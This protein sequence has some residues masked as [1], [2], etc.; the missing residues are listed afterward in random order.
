[1]NALFSWRLTGVFVAVKREWHLV[2][3]QESYF[4]SLPVSYMNCYILVFVSEGQSTSQKS[5]FGLELAKKE[6]R[7][8]FGDIGRDIATI[9]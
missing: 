8:L 6:A 3:A 9:H 7:V 1:M 5:A 2:L 4:V